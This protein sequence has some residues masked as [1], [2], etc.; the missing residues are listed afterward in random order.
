METYYS[1][2]VS[3]RAMRQGCEWLMADDEEE[4]VFDDEPIDLYIKM[5]AFQKKK[6]LA[7]NAKA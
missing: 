6:S 1:G 2:F 3:E 4:A 5:L 7:T